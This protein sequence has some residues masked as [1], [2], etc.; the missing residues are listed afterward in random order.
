M[1]VSEEVS[2]TLARGGP[3]VALESTLIA[4]GL[5]WP[6]NLET[7]RE[8]EAEVR[9]AGA[10]PATIA[11]IAGVP[12]IG[13]HGAELERLA[14]S[15]DVL[16]ASRRDLA[17]A[18]ARG[19]DA[20]TT[21]SATLS[22]ARR[23]GVRIMATG[24]LGGVHRGAA[25]TFDISNDLDELAR[26]DGMAVV[27]SGAKSILDLPATLEVLETLG[28]PVVGYQTDTLPAFLTRS[29]GLGLSI[30]AD[31]PAQAADII[32]AHGWLGLPGA[33]V[34][35][36]P[37]PLESALSEAAFERALQRALDFA[38]AS[39]TTGKELTPF[40]LGAIREATGGQA[41]IA[42]RALIVNNARLAGR[43][44][45]EADRV[46]GD[47]SVGFLGGPKT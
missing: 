44:A 10:V 5:P 16:K 23:A 38:T 3:L 13:L 22:L 30:R 9:Q 39:R 6:D 35:A 24:G 21:V 33:V 17:V 32:R 40:L 1:R 14:L 28:V 26:A 7:A 42:N 46:Q 36:Q 37:V 18:V 43:I 29:S 15:Q 4:H 19:L 31:D 34:I 47:S 45:L 25:T 12:R 27:C 20:A 2:Q 41:L 11:V 8:A